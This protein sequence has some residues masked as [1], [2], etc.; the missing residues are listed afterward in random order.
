MA[1]EVNPNKKYSL[2]RRCFSEWQSSFLIGGP[3]RIWNPRAIRVVEKF[4]SHSGRGCAV[5]LLVLGLLPIIL[6]SVLMV[7]QSIIYCAIGIPVL[8]LWILSAIVALIPEGL[9]HNSG[10]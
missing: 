4:I 1:Q 10:R 9:Q 5:K 8:L 7:R 2:L 3:L 6:L